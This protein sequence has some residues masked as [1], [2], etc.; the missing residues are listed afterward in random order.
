MFFL[1]NNICW[2][3]RKLCKQ[4]PKD[5]AGVNA[6]KQACVIVIFLH[7]LPYSNKKPTQNT[8]ETLRYHFL[9]TGYLQNLKVFTSKMR[10]QLF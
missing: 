5:Q 3:P 8:A 7:I 10:I 9:N 1:Y 2:V 4:F 6:M